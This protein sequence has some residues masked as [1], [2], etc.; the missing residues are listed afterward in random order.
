MQNRPSTDTGFGNTNQNISNGIS[1]ATPENPNRIL[2][3]AP[4]MT[5]EETQ[6][7]IHKHILNFKMD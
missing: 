2:R 3:L 6:S 4:N 1:M 7:I 5:Y